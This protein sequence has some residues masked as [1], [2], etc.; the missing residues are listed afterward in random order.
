MIKECA[1]IVKNSVDSKYLYRIGGDEFVIIY[2]DITE[3]SFCDNVQ[4]LKNAFE[5]SKCQAAIGCRWNEE[6]THIQDII[7]EADEL[8]YDDKSGSIRDTMQLAATGI[9]MTYCAPWLSLMC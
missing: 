6:C 7:K 2:V 3:E 1:D 9:I 8:M 5:K 4:L